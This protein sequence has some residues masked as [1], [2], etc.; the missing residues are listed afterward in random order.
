M[1]DFEP[2]IL[3]FLCN[4][5]SYAGADLAGV[6]RIQYPPN[7]RVIRV[8]C[9]GRLDPVIVL[10]AFRQGIDGVAVLGCHFGDCHYLTGNYQAERKMKLTRKVLRRTGLIPD[11][12]YLDWV[13]AAEGELFAKLVGDF[14]KKVK[15]LG[16]LG[17]PE[18]LAKEELMKRLLACQNALKT[19]KLRWLAGKELELVE[20]QNVYGEKIPQEEFDLVVNENIEK[21]YVRSRIA[22]LIEDRVL[23]VKEIAAQIDVSPKDVLRHIS[24][25]EYA[26]LVTMTGVKGR[27]PRYQKIGG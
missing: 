1:S 4:W 14:T 3:G 15:E 25:M 11:R 2:K 22:G 13:S 9:S 16:P 8:M 5:C 18:G 20:E 10:E 6:S 19:E 27:S 21:E 23:S 7:L 26:G 17:E 24:T 12:L